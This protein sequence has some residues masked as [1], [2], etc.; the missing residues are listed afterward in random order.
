MQ[1]P[2][3]RITMKQYTFTFTLSE[4]R[5]SLPNYSANDMDEV[6]LEVKYSVHGGSILVNEVLKDGVD[7]APVLYAFIAPIKFVQVLAED[8][9]EMRKVEQMARNYQPINPYNADAT[10]EQRREMQRIK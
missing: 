7:I 9:Y 4:H 10:P 8:N 5:E 1:N 2:P 6:E 3:I